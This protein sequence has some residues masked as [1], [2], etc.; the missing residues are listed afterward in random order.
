L[1]RKSP[2]AR[3]VNVVSAGQQRIDFSGVMLTRG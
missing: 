2:P 1:I 3:I